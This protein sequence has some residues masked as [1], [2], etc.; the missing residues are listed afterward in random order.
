[1][2][3][4]TAN[5]VIAT[6]VDGRGEQRK[7]QTKLDNAWRAFWKDK[8][9]STANN[10]LDTLDQ[11]LASN[12]TKGVSE[13]S[14]VL[15]ALVVSEFRQ[16]INGQPAAGTATLAVSVF[17]FDETTSDGK[18]EPAG[19]GVYLFVD[20]NHLASTDANGQAMLTVPAG[21][22]A[23][24]AIVPSTA[25]AEA[26]VVAS[27]GTTVPLQLILD[28]SKEVTSPVQLSVSGMTGDVLPSTFDS[29]AITLLDNGAS[30]AAVAVAEVAI[31]DDL[32]NTLERLTDDFQVDAFGRLLPPDLA[33]VA[34]AVAKYPGKALVL[35]VMAEDALGFT[36]LGTQPLY[37]GQYTLNVAL[38]APPSNPSLPVA[39]VQVT[40]Q[41]MGTGLILAGT[42]DGAGHLTFG[43]V[44]L[45][46]ANLDSVTVEA[47]R[48]YYG[49]A[50]F[51]LPRASQA[52]VTMTHADDIANG[53]PRFELLSLPN[54]T[55]GSSTS[56]DGYDPE[57]AAHREALHAQLN[58]YGDL[59]PMAAV[60]LRVGAGAANEP[61]SGSRSLTAS[62][63]TQRVILRYQVA[64]QEYPYYVN[65]QSI[66]NDTW[67]LS[68]H[69]RQS[70]QQLFNIARNVNSQLRNAP[71]WL[72]DGSTG[73]IE[74]SFDV[75]ALTTEGPAE[76]LLAAAVT[77]V[78]DS[79]L[80]T[81]VDADL[82]DDP[83]RLI[84]K[85]VTPERLIKTTGD[86]NSY[87]VPLQGEN[88]ILARWFTLT[89][90]KPDGAQVTRVRAELQHGSGAMPGGQIFEEGP[91][92]NVQVIDDTTLRVRV[93]LHAGGTVN[94][95]PPPAH[96]ITYKF[97]V[98]ANLQDGTEVSDDAIS[99][100]KR[101]L[102]R[103][104]AD[105]RDPARRY[106][107][108]DSG[109]DDWLSARTWD[110]IS[111]HGT[112]LTRIDDIS[113][114]HGRDIGH[115][116]HDVGTDIDLYHVYRFAG[117]TS[118][119]DN[120][121]RLR[122]ALI[123]VL[124]LPAEQTANDR[125]AITSWTADTR[126][127]FAAILSTTDAQT[128]YYAVGS[129]YTSS[130]IALPRGWARSLLVDGTVTASG[131]QLDTG[132]GA[133]GFPQDRLVYNAV[134]N[135]HFHIKRPRER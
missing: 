40:Y 31:E 101:A 14:K 27:E 133:W 11:L 12:A 87:S 93:T 24:Q 83:D 3:Y 123:R 127:R 117:A 57:I 61:V 121:N 71:V 9:L 5:V 84:V 68:V 95:V 19:E 33:V 72:P 7:L 107:M 35:R 52:R 34:N 30:R 88:N 76:L 128:L 22:V 32:G 4:D 39:G 48:Y 58:G 1:M 120:Y 104:P 63:G 50:S 41:L 79:F 53:V 134:H 26:T 111:Q 131:Q 8:Q 86:H 55:S 126:E 45:G 75:A 103:M 56:A 122:N 125:A 47:G 90:D 44:P 118:G 70:G 16:C 21:T 64:T 114:E 116:T 96:A 112:L 82:S 73:Y 43:Q 20:G 65:Q 37:L 98:F 59:T 54:A 89:L 66:Y 135:S 91:G 119:G 36:L 13:E 10:S 109:H 23:V 25:I 129:A 124:S 130:G 106:G 46:N 29:F 100:T 15:I 60:N 38:V 102:W 2:Y 6:E 132:L 92:A 62:Q 77:N 67:S 80:P 81:I 108:R 113:G 85:Q 49:Q 110:F 115:A 17:Y 18:G 42:S 105:W 94:T 28:D 97:T 51:F 69:A 74:E 99:A 78:A